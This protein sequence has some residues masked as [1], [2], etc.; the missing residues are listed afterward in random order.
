MISRRPVIYKERPE[1]HRTA[2]P[3]APPR[4]APKIYRPRD[5]EPIGTCLLCEEPFAGP[6]AIRLRHGCVQQRKW[7]TE[8]HQLPFDD[9]SKLKWLCP[10]CAWDN[11]I[12]A[13][14]GRRFS[15]RLN[16]LS[17]DGQCCLCKQVIEPYP[18]E[19]W[20]SAILIE[21]GAMQQSTK[22]AFSIFQPQ[23]SG[24]LHYFCM[25][26][27]NIELWRLIERS[28]APDY[29]EYLSHASG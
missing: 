18:L 27:F 5:P 24:H 21:L 29:T 6:D 13:D 25:D 7:G 28:D 4:V 3:S 9:L 1:T 19:E 12:V 8:F 17:D 15:P 2:V 20:S 22:G 23:Y 16:G 26:D 11:S 10:S 14:D